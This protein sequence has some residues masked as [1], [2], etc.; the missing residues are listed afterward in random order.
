MEHGIHGE[1]EEEVIK[2]TIRVV[3]EP[4]A[5]HLSAT[6]AHA[7]ARTRTRSNQFL[8]LLSV[9]LVKQIELEHEITLQ[10]ATM[11]AAG[12]KKHAIISTLGIADV[13]YEMSAYRLRSIAREWR[14]GV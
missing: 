3:N 4:L 2:E 1:D 12:V 8:G 5:L 11:I 13:V 9:E 7:H 14:D 10:V 6:S